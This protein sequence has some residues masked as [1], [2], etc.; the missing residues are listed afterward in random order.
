MFAKLTGI[1]GHAAD[2]ARHYLSLADK[3]VKLDQKYAAIAEGMIATAEKFIPAQ[4]KAPT[5]ILIPVPD[6]HAAALGAVPLA[7]K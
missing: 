2:F 5:T 1:F 4:E 7:V 3:G 6:A